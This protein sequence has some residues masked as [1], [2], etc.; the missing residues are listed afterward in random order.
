[1][2]NPPDS[3]VVDLAGQAFTWESDTP[4]KTYLIEFIDDD[5]ARPV[6]SAFTEE[7]Y[8]KVPPPVAKYRFTPGRT[9]FWRIKSF[10]ASHELVSESHPRQ[11][12]MI[13]GNAYDAE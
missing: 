1:L 2:I 7:L 5:P 4:M 3:A 8:Y 10:S 12:Q 6:A 9:Y 13:G 11:F